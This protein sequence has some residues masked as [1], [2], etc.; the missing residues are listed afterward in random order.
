MRP[1]KAQTYDITTAR[2]NPSWA[3]RAD[4][5][6]LA[7]SEVYFTSKRGTKPSCIACRV[8]ENAPEITACDAITVAAVDSTT[9]GSN[10]PVG[11]QMVERIV[12]TARIGE[13]KALLGQS[14]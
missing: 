4:K 2:N 11:G 1:R 13:Q 5:S 10:L 3:Y 6:D 9:S 8:T 7:L 12:D 14:S